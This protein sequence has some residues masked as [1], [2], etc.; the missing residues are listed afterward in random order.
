MT[1][2]HDGRGADFG[3]PAVDSAECLLVVGGYRHNADRLDWAVNEARNQIMMSPTLADFFELRFVDMGPES[4]TSSAAGVAR[5]VLELTSRPDEAARNF[6]A[7][8]VVD[9]SAETVERTL[10]DCADDQVLAD[11]RVKSR[12]LASKEDRGHPGTGPEIFIATDG[13][14]WQLKDIATEICRYADTLLGDFGSGQERGLTGHR[15]DEL[16]ARAE[17]EHREVADA[18]AEAEARAAFEA[19]QAH[20]ARQRADRERKERE[21]AERARAERARAERERAEWEKRYAEERRLSEKRAQ[22]KDRKGAAAADSDKRAARDAGVAPETE[23][24]ARDAVHQ[25]ER[26]VG[27]P[28]GSDTPEQPT[29]VA[30]EP[31][32][33]DVDEAGTATREAIPSGP[34]PRSELP[35][36]ADAVIGALDSG[37]EQLAKL[38]NRR[39]LPAESA[40]GG[41]GA[42]EQLIV[43]CGDRLRSGDEKGFKARL[44]A[45]RSY[46]DAEIGEKERRRYRVIVKE[47]GLLRPGLPLGSSA[48]PFYDVLLRLA[49]GLPLSYAHYCEVEDYLTSGDGKPQI[50]SRALLEAI[51]LGGGGHPDVRV[52]AIVCH[53]LGP[54]RLEKWFRSRELD[55]GQ[56]VAALDGDWERPHHQDIAFRVTLRYLYERAGHFDPRRVDA[57]L[58]AHGYLAAALKRAHGDSVRHQLTVLTA[59]LRA[60]YPRGLDRPAVKEIF[61]VSAPTRALGSAVVRAVA[62]PADR[63][64]AAKLFLAQHGYTEL[65]SEQVAELV[66]RFMLD[67]G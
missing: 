41:T 20:A 11:L 46:A 26:P 55:V 62:V 43:E 60:A 21:R 56:L 44:K 12:G 2:T 63:S 48:V 35:R 67:D 27:D 40:Q 13:K 45:L 32:S 8:L 23:K 59:L 39:A 38:I 65:G 58:R 24:S 66:R 25:T 47:G 17:S 19:A 52:K 5:L 36:V 29:P 14:V 9:Q 54:E 6:S 18:A 49:F 42:V 31:A 1:S 50:P 22:A 64:W 57:A 28:M 16:E 7:L 51:D 15:L 3:S 53:H 33:H 61:A 37:A 34:A 30:G 4:P 10:R